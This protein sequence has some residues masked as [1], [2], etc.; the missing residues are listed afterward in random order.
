MTSVP[1]YSLGFLSDPNYLTESLVVEGADPVFLKRALEKMLMI[2]ST[3]YEI[4]E[5]VKAGQVKCPCH[6]AIGQEAISVGLAEALTPQD[7]AFGNHR[8]HAHYLAMGGSLQGLFDEVLGRATGCSKGMGGSMHIFAGDVGF[9]GSVPIVAGTIPIAVGAA[10][11]SKMDK[12]GTIAVAFFGDGACEEGVVHECLNIASV[13]SLPMVFVVE[14]NLYSSHLD[15]M[16]RQPYD[17]TARFAEAH[18]IESCVLDGNDVVTLA[19]TVKKRI[20]EIRKQPRP[21]F[22]E[23]V[24]FR[25]LG[26]VGPNE[27]IDVGVRRSGDELNAWKQRDPIRRLSDAMIDASI[28]TKEEFSEL[29][30]KIDQVVVAAKNQAGNAPWPESD[31]MTDYVY[32]AQSNNRGNDA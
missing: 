23:A 24:T 16:Q 21:L 32:K 9:H 22:I 13:M 7:R 17:S 3:E 31:R 26:H 4:A 18:R 28:M 12:K 30:Y 19:E 20:G 29:R 1:H 25:W 11:A 14:N 2:R 5:M 27:D 8:S 10:L 6:L 15:I